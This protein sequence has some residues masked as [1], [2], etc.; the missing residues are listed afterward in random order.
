MLAQI[1]GRV[2]IGL[3]VSVRGGI[4]VR[5]RVASSKKIARYFPNL[6]LCIT[7]RIGFCKPDRLSIL[8][9]ELIREMSCQS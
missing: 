4:R 9:L 3:G 6:D 2:G 8:K 7:W 5:I 1:L